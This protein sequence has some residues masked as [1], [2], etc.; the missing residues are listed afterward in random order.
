MRSR[1]KFSKEYKQEAVR[2]WEQRGMQSASENLGIDKSSLYQ[3]RKQLEEEVS[4]AFRGNGNRT[5]LEEGPYDQLPCAERPVSVKLNGNKSRGKALMYSW[6]SN[7]QNAS[8][9][10]PNSPSPVLTFR[11]TPLDLAEVRKLAGCEPHITG[12]ANCQVELTVEESGKQVGQNLAD[13]CA[14]PIISNNCSIHAKPG[15][16]KWLDCFLDYLIPDLMPPN[17]G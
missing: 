7:C 12:P 4:E 10:D 13:H 6:T 16:H 17:M 15:F 3:W 1:K 8:F 5:V 9:D 11:N 2:L 14:A